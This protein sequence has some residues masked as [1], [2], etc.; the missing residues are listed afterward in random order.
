MGTT[1]GGASSSMMDIGYVAQWWTVLQVDGCKLLLLMVAS[2]W[3]DSWFL[4][5]DLT[6]GLISRKTGCGR[7]FS[8]GFRNGGYPYLKTSGEE[9]IHQS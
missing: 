9:V 8:A 3:S 7:A 5:I 4:W 2:C 1:S 6:Q